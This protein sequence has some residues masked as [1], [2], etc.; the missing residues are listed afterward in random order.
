MQQIID[1][2]KIYINIEFE[3]VID[4]SLLRPTDEPIIYGDSSKLKSDTKWKQVYTH[5]DTIKSMI[6]YWRKK[7]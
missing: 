4:K 3:T 6:N 2:I 1:I 7:L 5:E